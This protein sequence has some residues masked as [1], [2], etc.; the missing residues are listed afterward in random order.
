MP[1]ETN[2]SLVQLITDAMNEF[3]NLFQ[4]EI[5]L[6][7]VELSEKLNR[8]A[9]SG[10]M[11]GAGAVAAIVAL[12]LLLQAAVKW[13][14]IAGLPEEWGLLLLGFLVGVIGIV[15]LVKGIN[16]AKATSLLPERTI[17]QVRADIATVKEHV[18]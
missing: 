18:T 15:L 3:A 5:R 8:F 1:Q 16:D 10:A 14:A 4:T 13:L 12:I 11:I 17:S 6:V 2:R 9:G 7:R